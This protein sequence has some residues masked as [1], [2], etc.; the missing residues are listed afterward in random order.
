[1]LSL[2]LVFIGHMTINSEE[3]SR[4]ATARQELH[5]RIAWEI[6]KEQGSDFRIVDHKLYA[7]EHLL[8]G[9]LEVVDKVKELVGGTATIFMR[10]IRVATNVMKEDGTR[11]VGTVLAQGP[12]YNAVFKQGTSYRGEADILGTR[13]FTAYDPI[14][15]S[16]GEV[17]G[18]LYV[19]IKKGEFFASTK[20]ILANIYF[21]VIGFGILIFLVSFITVRN[22]VIRPVVQG[23]AF[24]KDISRG[25]FTNKVMTKRR[26]ELGD[27]FGSFSN[28]QTS[29]TGVIHGIR[30]GTNEVT[31]ASEQVMKGNTDLS[32]RT[33]E[34][35][36]SLE[37]VAS[38]MEEMT[39]TVNQNAENA[40]LASQLAQQARVQ[41]DAGGEVAGRAVAAMNEINAASRKIA[42][43][44]G[45]I[46]EIAFQTN[47]LAL[48]AAVEAAR[49]GEHGRGFAVVANEV[50]NLAGR[51]KTSAK[52][53]KDLI[54]DSVVKVADGMKLV[55]E[56]GAAL[57]EILL[58]VK[59]VSDIVGEIATAS[60]EQ[61]DGINQ[62][63]KALLQM[64]GMTQQ[65]ASM[66]EQATAVSEAM[67][68]QAE[69]L[70]SLVAY[71]KLTGDREGNNF[72]QQD[73]SRSRAGLQAKQQLKLEA[74]SPQQAL[75]GM[76]TGAEGEWRE[77]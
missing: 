73:A 74:K 65:N 46:D 42:D 43:I 15:N 34:Q 32:Q 6:L 71:F 12:A 47:L 8:N 60:R 35:A 19:G 68:A 52:E 33:Q 55:D 7:G 3:M 77:F 22:I 53:I 40:M 64:D 24:A 1:L 29:L 67:R 44:I 49:A 38:S 14:K 58:E 2:S 57:R 37:E 18:V 56:S 59:K 10:D 31:L 25:I 11:A 54:K 26:D 39:S 9:N 27:L 16:A 30:T 76:I 17:I 75:P 62:V 69:E 51:A 21:T 28:M 72:A 48:N 63:N 23:A 36:S 45:V 41:A 4:Q 5:M 70:N 66:V 61:A 13:Y 20:K 50:R